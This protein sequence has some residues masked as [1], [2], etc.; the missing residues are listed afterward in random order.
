M[1]YLPPK[2]FAKVSYRT[3]TV[4]YITV[5]VPL[6]YRTKKERQKSLTRG[7]VQD[8]GSA[9]GIYSYRGHGY[10]GA[11]SRN[12]FANSRHLHLYVM[13]VLSGARVV[14]V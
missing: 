6:I 8:I 9:L 12:C 3:I 14:R 13:V 1:S 5:I 11:M 4:Q 7:H 10:E 2:G